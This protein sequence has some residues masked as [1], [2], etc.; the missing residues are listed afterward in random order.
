MPR[1]IDL[2]EPTPTR[3]RDRFVGR[4]RER[5]EFRNSV[6][7][8]LEWE[9]PPGGSSL[10]PHIFLPHGEGGM[11]KS[12]L[13]RQFVQIARQEGLP[14]SQIVVLD[15]DSDI[16]PTAE[17]L[18]QKLAI[19]VRRTSPEFDR[20]Y[21]AARTRR[22]E[23][24]PRMRE[25]K[26]QWARWEALRGSSAE[27]IDK[28]LDA[29]RRT[30]RH[31]ETQQAGFGMAA[32]PYMAAQA[33]E[34]RNELAAL[35]AFRQ[36]RGRV[37]DTFQELLERELGA[38]DAA[39]FLHDRGLGQALADDLFALAEATPLLLAL[40]T[41]E[42]ADQH[43]DWLR[44]T[45]LASGSSRMLTIIAGRNRHDDAYRRTFMGNLA[46]LV[47]SYNLNDQTLQSDEVREYL[48]LRLDADP[49]DA[50]VEEI[51]QISRGI[52][53]AV[54]ALGDQL[55]G[56][57]DIAPYRGMQ[58]EGLD[59]RGVVHR[60]TERFL[61][62]ALDDK[63]D[64]ETAREIKR[65]DRQRIRA[66]SLLL[67]P[68]A[69]LACALWGCT[70]GDAQQAVSRSSDRYSFIFA[71]YEPYEMHDLVREFVRADTLTDGRNGFDWPALAEGLRRALPVVDQRLALTEQRIPDPDERYA[72]V[73]WRDATLDR[74]NILLWLGEDE[75]A[76]RLLLNRWIEARYA[77]AEFATQLV[78][79][80]GELAPKRKDWQGLLTAVQV[81]E[82]ERLEVY[83]ERIEPHAREEY[84][85]LEVYSERIEL[86]ACVV[87]CYLRARHLRIAW[88]KSEDDLKRINQHIMLLDQGH[89][90]D[91]Q[92]EPIGIELAKAY[93][94]RGVYIHDQNHFA[95]AL[96][97]FER[98]LAFRPDHPATLHNRGWVKDEL[99]DYAGALADYD[100]SLA[101]RRD[102]PDTLHNRGMVK[103]QLGDYAGAL[104]DYDRSLIL[105][106]DDPDTIY[107]LACLFALQ[108]DSDTSLDWLAKAITLDESNRNYARTDPDFDPIRADPRLVAL[109]GDASA[110]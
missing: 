43:D 70:A 78:E 41:Y 60:V 10:Y 6:R 89:A 50:L 106:P 109:V 48:R 87:L 20:R 42:L 62:Y 54:E 68:D 97:D 44:M 2:A 56:S 52:P 74:L 71:S 88:V 15:L 1:L 30:L 29:H 53:L 17:A 91:Q 58:A 69:A 104:A 16:Y 49:T 61:R 55:A 34:S 37:P 33:Y 83:S 85:R 28:L 94:S 98:S 36:D 79:L 13:L 3:S 21:R 14:E 18:A 103:G 39:L 102:D 12:A 46:S 99:G 77:N 27:D 57:G 5:A 19:A 64:D 9:L 22:D 73:E 23:L 72:D 59:R 63:T 4:E 24:A 80:A 81:E 93:A 107:N 26:E 38:D 95:E 8:V 96:A 25:L 67:R 7:Y 51:L 90:L 75:T 40:D 84:E 45:I 31:A 35:L 108:A 110:G 82:Y 65:Q 100:R 66:L 32:L 11:G 101:L 47:R 105:Q 86:H 76:K 92:W